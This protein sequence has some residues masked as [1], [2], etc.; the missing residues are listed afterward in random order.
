[1]AKFNW[2]YINCST[3]GEAY[4][5]TGSVQFMSG[6]NDT[7]GSA[8]FMFYSGSLGGYAA[9]TL[10][11][12]G[13]LVVSGTISASHYHIKNVTE[14]D[15]SGST[16]FGDSSDDVH[17]RT[18]SLYIGK[19]ASAP[20]F[21]VDSPNEQIL[22]AAP[23]SASIVSGSGIGHFLSLDVNSSTATVSSA[24][25]IAGSTVSGSGAGSGSS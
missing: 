20:L 17:I 23:L 13:T 19:S 2:A 24:G 5:P 8:N 21:S 6:S 14:I 7:T 9:N 25:A 4:G 15:S 12:T 22:F 3:L 1:M 10:V 18:G 16:Y 11:L